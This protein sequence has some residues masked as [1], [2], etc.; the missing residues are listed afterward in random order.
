MLLRDLRLSY[1]IS[2]KVASSSI[3][4]PL[5][6]YIRY[7][8]Q[9]DETNIKYQKMVDLL[10][11]KY[12]INEQKGILSLE[13]IK[14]TVQDIIS[15]YGDDINY[16]YLFGSYAKGYASESSDVDLCIDT[17]LTGLKYVGLIE[18]LHSSLKKNVDLIRVQDIVNNI[19]LLNEIMKDGVKIYG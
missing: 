4:V 19:D 13:Y 5:R 16:C 14:S 1:G 6:T 7:E 15:S 17:K 3:N 11:E 18:K 12:E 8:N 9:E 10:K 2:Q